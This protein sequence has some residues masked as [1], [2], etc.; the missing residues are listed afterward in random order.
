MAGVDT[1][2]LIVGGGLAGLSLASRLE[3]SGIDWQLIEARSRLGGRIYSP[4]VRAGS[5]RARID[6]GPAW[7]WPGQPRIAALVQQYGL[8]VFEQFATGAQ[9]YEDE[10]GGVFRDQGFASMAG[11]L[12]VAGGLG[13]TI[14]AVA[15]QLDDSRLECNSSL[16]AIESAE[17]GY[18]AH[19]KR[20]EEI[21]TLGCKR[22]ALAL[23]PRVVASEVAAP[24]IFDA[25][26]IDQMNSVPTWM[27]GHAKA[28]AVYRTPFWRESGLS[29]DAMSRRGPL[30]EIHDA[31]PA[32]DRFGALFGFSGVPASARAGQADALREACL[33]QLQSLFGPQAADTTEVA[34]FDWAFEPETA[35][36]LD[37]QL[38]T[39]HPRYGMPGLLGALSQKG[40]VFCS[41]EV[42]DTFG[43]YIEGALE[44]AEAAAIKLS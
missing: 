27:A 19:I 9:M 35:T 5:S 44:A 29:G 28:V 8:K 25:A 2:V 10:S 3:A 12:R 7:F 20:A 26:L 39:H 43:G 24:E 30:V 11:S 13:V 21:H 31:S 41:T 16:T 15:Q 40:I 4:E 33:M 23:P 37:H 18:T 34:L 36:A 42:A 17:T 6:A 22:I 38:L 1:D 14:E 32:D